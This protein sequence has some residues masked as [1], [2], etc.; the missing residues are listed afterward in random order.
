MR[1]ACL[2]AEQLRHRDP[3]SSSLFPL[4]MV[5]HVA[6]AERSWFLRSSSVRSHLH[7]RYGVDD[8]HNA[9]DRVDNAARFEIVGVRSGCGKPILVRRNLDAMRE[10][11]DGRTGE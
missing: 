6:E 11:I 7:T 8:P 5:R 2:D 1:S 9:V 4:G 10:R 3:P